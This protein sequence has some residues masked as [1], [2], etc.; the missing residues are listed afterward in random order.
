MYISLPTSPATH[1]SKRKVN[2]MEIH[3]REQRIESRTE[4]SVRVVGADIGVVWSNRHG[5]T[6]VARVSRE[7][8]KSSSYTAFDLSKSPAKRDL[9]KRKFHVKQAASYKGA[10]WRSP[11][12]RGSE[13][14]A[15]SWKS[16]C[17]TYLNA[18][19]ND[20]VEDSIMRS[21]DGRISI[22][23]NGGHF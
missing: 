19:V 2:T 15:F 21:T 12:P 6:L 4:V 7:E 9:T 16:F 10:V 5:R 11:F 13:F 18:K 22:R 20:R 1:V 17:S 23:P 3:S 14:Y 8:L